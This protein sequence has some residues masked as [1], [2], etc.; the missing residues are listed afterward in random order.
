MELVGAAK[1]P[2]GWEGLNGEADKGSPAEARDAAKSARSVQ[3]SARFRR[4]KAV[5]HIGQLAQSAGLTG[6]LPVFAKRSG[7]QGTAGQT[8]Q[9]G[10]GALQQA[11]HP[12]ALK[13][14]KGLRGQQ[15]A[16]RVW[17]R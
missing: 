5:R 4:V 15:Q 16:G 8:A 13:L 1:S 14:S 7:G 6:R 11:G 2:V 3:Q 17:A 9:D 10:A 12:R